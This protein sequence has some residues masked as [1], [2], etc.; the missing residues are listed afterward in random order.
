MDAKAPM[1]YA[2]QAHALSRRAARTSS[3]VSHTAAII[4]RAYGRASMPAH[5]VRGRIAEKTPEVTAT[6]R[7]ENCLASTTTPAAAPPTA[8]PLGARDQ[9]SVGGKTWNQPC[10][11]R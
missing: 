9:N 4:D 8:R 11:S 2:S 10:M 6:V 3:T 7:D 1:P 5:V